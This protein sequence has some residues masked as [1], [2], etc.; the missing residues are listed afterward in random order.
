[1]DPTWEHPAAA[2][3]PAPLRPHV[4]AMYGYAASGLEP[5]VHRGLPSDGLTLV[6]SLDRPLRT[7]PTEQAWLEASGTPTG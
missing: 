7:A 4:E 6:L 5:G 2:Q 1:M 3:I